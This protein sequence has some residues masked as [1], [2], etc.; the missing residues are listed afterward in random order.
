MADWQKNDDGTFT[1]FGYGRRIED[2]KLKEIMMDLVAGMSIREV[3][4]DRRLPER[5][6]REVF[7]FFNKMTDD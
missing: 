6:V 4:K 2:A 5:A 7:K 1:Y 3:A